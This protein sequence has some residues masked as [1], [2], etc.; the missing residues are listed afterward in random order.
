MDEKWNFIDYNGEVKPIEDPIPKNTRDRAAQV[1]H[2]IDDVLTREEY[3]DFK[4]AL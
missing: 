2:D 1:P 4:Q 3:D